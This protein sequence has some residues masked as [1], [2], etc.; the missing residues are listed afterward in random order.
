MPGTSAERAESGKGARRGVL[1]ALAL[2]VAGGGIAWIAAPSGEVVTLEVPK[3]VVEERKIFVRAPAPKV[4]RTQVR[5]APAE[6]ESA[7]ALIEHLE[8]LESLADRVRIIE[9]IGL[10]GDEEAVPKLAELC[11]ST[12]PQIRRSAIEALGRVGG[13]DAVGLLMGLAETAIPAERGQAV[14]ALGRTG[15]ADAV[16]WLIE[17]GQ[18]GGPLAASA[19][20]A[21]ASI[22]GEDIEQFLENRMHS[23]RPQEAS[24]AAQALGSLGTERARNALVWQVRSGSQRMV[25]DAALRALARF[26]DP[27]SRALVEN[28]ASGGDMWLAHSAVNALAEIG[29]PKA[30]ETL[31]VI[32]LSGHMQV[33]PTAMSA[34]GRIGTEDA[35]DVLIELLAVV[36]ATN[37]WAL[38]N[39]LAAFGDAEVRQAL[40]ALLKRNDQLAG[41]ALGALGQIAWDDATTEA[42]IAILRS[43]R[44][45]LVSQAAQALA[46]QLGA[47]ALPHLLESWERVPMNQ[48]GMLLSAIGQINSP[49]AVDFLIEQATNS[50]PHLQNWIISAMHSMGPEAKRAVQDA[51]MDQYEA[52][53]TMAMMQGTQAWTLAQIGG[54]RARKLLLDAVNEGAPQIAIT[55][56]QA[57]ASNADDATIEAMVDVLA[58]EDLPPQKREGM[59]QALASSNNPLAQSHVLEIAR[60]SDG[61]EAARAL[62]M[63]GW[64]AGAE[65]VEVANEAVH[66]DKPE[67]R[68]AALSVLTHAGG[69]Q[70]VD[71]AMELLDDSDSS[72]RSQ[73]MQ[74]LGQNGSKEAVGAL[75][76]AYTEGDETMRAQVSHLLVNSGQ[77]EAIKA[78]GQALEESEGYARS[79]ALNA[80]LYSQS[81]KAMEYLMGVAEGSG[82]TADF[83]R[84]ELIRMGYMEGELP[85][86]PTSILG[87]FEFLLD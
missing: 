52:A 29:D 15:S 36:D 35:R 87:P 39:A 72:V 17:L 73:A 14:A 32:A 59:L 68:R 2:L 5:L 47:D 41:A 3:T 55:A 18:R 4:E 50:P 60:H 45:Y 70:A 9:R 74:L 31:K 84:A 53:G 61:P 85:P 51:L 62:E 7:E 54:E 82:G 40:V 71:V 8:T 43:G 11:E 63:V 28:V 81:P 10:V 22:G 56:A 34:L 46:S 23:G 67:M 58:A 6:S 79:T 69:A 27:E 24:A 21:L 13:S 78:V 86:E 19:L 44:N 37:A 76:G 64:R 38:T 25:R 16:S 77:P 12:Q 57:L 30:V 66:S 65:A 48:R 1:S 49:E 75:I 20:N 80:L 26:G 42:V 83:V 33:R